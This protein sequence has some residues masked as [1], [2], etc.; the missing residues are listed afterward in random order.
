[1]EGGGEGEGL[2]AAGVAVRSLANQ[3][4]GETALQVSVEDPSSPLGSSSSRSG[5]RRS[6][7]QSG[8]SSFS[9]LMQF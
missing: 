3:A 9:N 7:K 4:Q 1:M 5:P 2:E 8:T 6:V